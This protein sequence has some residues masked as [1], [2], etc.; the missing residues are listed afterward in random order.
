[1]LGGLG[2]DS[3]QRVWAAPTVLRWGLVLS[4]EFGRGAATSRTRWVPPAIG[5]WP[6]RRGVVGGK[7]RLSRAGLGARG[8]TRDIKKRRPAS[9]AG[10]LPYAGRC[11]DGPQSGTAEEV[12]PPPRAHRH[13]A[14][15][16]SCC[17]SSM[18]RR[19]HGACQRPLL[20]RDVLSRP[21]VCGCS[22]LCSV[23][24]RTP[25]EIH[26]AGAQRAGHGNPMQGE[27][28]A[29]VLRWLLS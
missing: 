2:A 3:P 5:T 22:D 28:L 16:A 26:R 24:A 7:P 4:P 23:Q 19:L 10:L 9:F 25:S 18:L 20:A 15:I 14:R 29:V 8:F 21:R 6:C 12:R 27:T 11:E 13:P 1:M 17:E